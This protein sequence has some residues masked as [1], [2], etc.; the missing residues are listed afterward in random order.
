MRKLGSGP[1]LGFRKRGLTL[2]FLALS[3]PAPHLHFERVGPESGPLP[4]VITAVRQDRAGFLWIGSRRGLYLYDGYSFR[5]FKND[6]G[7]P[8]S[9]SDHVI[10]AILED[11]KGR[12]WIGTNAGGLERLDRA[13]WTFEH[14]RHDASDPASLT[15]DS[16]TTLT[17]GPDGALWVGTQHGLNRLGP[18]TR[19]FER[20]NAGGSYVL[21]LHFDRGGRLWIATADGGLSRLDPGAAAL[22]VFRHDAKDPA[23]ISSDGVFEVVEDA[24]GAIWVGTADG[25]DRWDGASG[26]FAHTGIRGV[27]AVAIAPEAG[28]LWVATFGAGLLELDTASGR[29][30]AHAADATRRDAVASDRVAALA[31]GA[32]GTLWVGTWGGGLQRLTPAA[33]DLAGASGRAR[34]PGPVRENLS[35]LLVTR[36]GDL[37]IGTSDGELVRRG[38]TPGDDVVVVSRGPQV[39]ALAEDR[40]G[41]IWI[42]S[43][44]GIQ[45]VDPA[46]KTS[47]TLAHR[48]DDPLSLGPGYVRAILED[49]KGTM[50]VGTGEGGVQRIDP[51]RKVRQR[52]LQED[53]VTALAEDPAGTLW[54]GTRSGGLGELDPATGAATRFLPSAS[55]P[56]SLGHRTVTSI[57]VDRA[58]RTWI[59]TAGGGLHLVERDASG[60]VRFRRVTRAQGLVDDDVTAILEDDDGSLWLSTRQG[61]ARY[62][63]ASHTVVN[64]GGPEGVPA[65]EFEVGSA[66]RSRDTLYFGGVRGLVTV[67]AG[68][69]RRA[70]APSPTVV[71][72][73]R[74]PRGELAADR[75]V[76]ELDRLTVPY[77]SWV[78]LEMAVLDFAAPERNLYAYRV[79]G[80]GGEWIDLG[81]RRSVTFTDLSPGKHAFAAKGR[82]GQG[83][84]SDARTIDIV[85][86]PPF[87]MTWW[88]R[89]ASAG[90]LAGIA[91]GAHRMRTSSLARRNRQ[92]L[93]LQ[94]QRERAQAELRAAY[95]RLRQLTRRFEAAKEEERKRIARELHDDLGPSL[96][97]VIINLQ[98][99]ADPAQGG[100]SARRLAESTELVDRIIQQIRDLS[101]ALRPPLLDELGLIPALRGYLE[102]TAERTG[103][104]LT[105][106]GDPALAGLPPEVEITAFRVAQEAITN[107]VRHAGARRATTSIERE[108]GRLVVTVED[109]GAG[110]DVAAA[111]GAAAGNAM[112]L[113][114]M[115]ERVQ[116]LGGELS[117]EA[118][119]GRGTRVRAELPLEAAS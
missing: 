19:R 98:L 54:V 102:A 112:G 40:A 70:M 85:V 41:S 69:P 64:Y 39:L 25:V 43:A 30:V 26:T 33:L 116:V 66:S 55:D 73:I 48:A 60:T 24:S 11:T 109:D 96:T 87:W 61:L 103:L 74:T 92:L 8:A 108:N 14:F 63:P 5:E 100:A 2:F 17:E 65:A 82:N 119:P 23:S 91:L 20:V 29:A 117:I 110:F 101:L 89:V 81:T 27:G 31:R 118:A 50:W 37:W 9:I 88:F 28:R 4:E 49:R 12:L 105:F 59:G 71:S 36:G 7:D 38:T 42:G 45:V 113:L 34:L 6:P 52:F 22:T 47:L 53:Y 16:V 68:L 35:A 58:G 13:T 99:L 57:L 51:D 80:P 90:A 79:G 21:A 72:A 104:D 106:R 86:P 62:D 44:G 56:G 78:S 46:G 115:Q 95:D 18:E 10:R 107:V 94:A 111:M 1:F 83:V 67:P 32:D 93:D 84:W 75:P 77:G 76:W 97:A 3:A 114:G 15:H